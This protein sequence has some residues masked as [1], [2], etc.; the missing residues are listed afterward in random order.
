MK[1]LGS[2][3]IVFTILILA[4][5]DKDDEKSDRFNFLTGAVWQSDSLLMNGIDASVPGLPL[6]PFK[7]EA[8]FH[9]D[10]TGD[11][12]AYSGTWR[13]A[14]NETEL[15]INSDSLDFPLATQIEELTAISLKVTTTFPNP[16]EPTSPMLLRLTFKAK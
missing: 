4:S 6:E 7:G 8:V 15:V 3:L 11:F 16:L 9:K 1:L 12:G 14:Q 2:L 10:G 5:C 13:F